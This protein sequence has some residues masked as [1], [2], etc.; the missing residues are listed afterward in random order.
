MIRGGVWEGVDR[1]FRPDR[2]G[3]HKRNDQED[4]PYEKGFGD[5]SMKEE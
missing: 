4:D 3:A 1:S 5:V 2:D